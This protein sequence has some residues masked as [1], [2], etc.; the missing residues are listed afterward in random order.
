MSWY[1]RCDELRAME[2]LLR[3]PVAADLTWDPDEIR[4][5]ATAAPAP[6]PDVST[7]EVE[8]WVSGR[9]PGGWPELI[10]ALQRK[11]PPALWAQFLHHR[12]KID[13][14]FD[15]LAA[16]WRDPAAPDP[17]WLAN[18]VPT[19]PPVVGQAPGADQ[20][21]DPVEGAGH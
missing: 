13:A 20:A 8:T 3:P 15:A 18:P 10:D 14:E 17:R 21:G 16:F 7:K 11:E 9:Y 6:G 19:S 5:R 12:A 1:L 4:A 2:G